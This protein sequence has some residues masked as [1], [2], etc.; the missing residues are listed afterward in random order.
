[1]KLE[2]N[3]TPQISGTRERTSSW[4]KIQRVL[5]GQMAA[6]RISIPSEIV[7]LAFYCPF[8][9]IRR[10]YRCP[11]LLKLNSNSVETVRFIR[12]NRYLFAEASASNILTICHLMEQGTGRYSWLCAGWYSPPT[13]RNPREPRFHTI[14]LISRLV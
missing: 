13:Q 1:M 4:E 14:P 3:S 7:G 9:S 8:S 5:G 10:S 2:L 11:T 6:V 12:K